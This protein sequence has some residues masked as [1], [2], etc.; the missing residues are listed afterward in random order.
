MDRR[1]IQTPNSKSANQ[2][3]WKRR[4]IHASYIYQFLAMALPLFFLIEWLKNRRC[5]LLRIMF[6]CID[7]SLNLQMQY[8]FCFLLHWGFTGLRFISCNHTHGQLVIATLLMDKLHW[9][10][11]DTK[12]TFF[13]HKQ[14]S[15]L[16]KSGEEVKMSVQ[17]LA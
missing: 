13:R 12:C 10:S 5:A 1:G 16:V 17:L 11:N 3:A 9:Q 2:A 15:A 4:L 6:V 7:C 8:H 14:T